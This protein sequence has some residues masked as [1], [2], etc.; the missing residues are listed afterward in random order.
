MSGIYETLCEVCGKHTDHVATKNWENARI[1]IQ[2]VHSTLGKSKQ[3]KFDRLTSKCRNLIIPL[4]FL[5]T[6]VFTF[7]SGLEK[8]VKFESYFRKPRVNVSRSNVEKDKLSRTGAKRV[9]IFPPSLPRFSKVRQKR[10]K[11][12][13]KLQTYLRT[14]FEMAVKYDNEWQN[15]HVGRYIRRKN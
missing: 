7:E 6:K 5:K 12:R 9:F 13:E 1:E 15:K 2:F 11:N 4:A 3:T 10:G 14:L 8:Y